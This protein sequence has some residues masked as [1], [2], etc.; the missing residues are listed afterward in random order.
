MQIKCFQ[1]VSKCGLGQTICMGT[2]GRGG[3]GRLASYL[4]SFLPNPRPEVWDPGRSGSKEHLQLSPV[5]TYP[6]KRDY[7][8][9]SLWRTLP[10]LK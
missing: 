3:R 10:G 2:K 6:P 9:W 1:K 7:H 4:G 8:P 5:Y